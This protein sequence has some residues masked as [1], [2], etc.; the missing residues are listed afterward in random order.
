[1]IV[2]LSAKARG[3]PTRWPPWSCEVKVAASLELI[4]KW[5]VQCSSNFLTPGCAVW[6]TVR[7]IIFLRNILDVD[8]TKR[9]KNALTW[10]TTF[11]LS[12]TRCYLTPRRLS[13]TV[14]V[15]CQWAGVSFPWQIHVP[16][17]TSGPGVYLALTVASA[18]RL[19]M[20]FFLSSQMGM[21][22]PNW[23]FH[24]T[25]QAARIWAK[26]HRHNK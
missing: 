20:S 7:N 18:P 22:R 6:Q 4:L 13:Y 16:A 25:R 24:E 8:K 14:R 5:Q 3:S 23:T 10:L 15:A 12:F 21:H 26:T 19:A 1:M 17:N 2:C 11:G 9:L